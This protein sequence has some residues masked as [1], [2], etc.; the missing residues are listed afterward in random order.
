MNTVIMLA[1]WQ[2]CTAALA[3]AADEP[4]VSPSP[5]E[6]VWDSPNP[7]CNGTMPLGSGEIALNAWI[8]PSGDLR[9]YIAG[10]TVGMTAAVW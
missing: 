6:V 3:L 7:N 10:P 5:Y 1:G 9:F 8:E 4:A 2:I